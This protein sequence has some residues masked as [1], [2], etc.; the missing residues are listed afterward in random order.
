M[1]G[2]AVFVAVGYVLVLKTMGLEPP[3][4]KLLAIVVMLGFG[5]VWIAKRARK[6]A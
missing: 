5:F 1:L 3:Y 2:P 6:K 4:L